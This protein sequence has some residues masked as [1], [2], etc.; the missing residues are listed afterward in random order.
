M[1]DKSLPGCEH[2]ARRLLKLLESG[3]YEIVPRTKIKGRRDVWGL[4]DD[5]NGRMLIKRNL[6]L[7]EARRTLIHEGVHAL[8]PPDEHPHA[9]EEAVEEKALEVDK[10]IGPRRKKRFESFLPPDD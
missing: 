10:H 7:G 8:F 3:K 2:V 5:I 1:Q 6:P 9:T 4:H